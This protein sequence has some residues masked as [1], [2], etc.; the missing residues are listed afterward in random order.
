MIYEGVK[1]D[2]DPTIV[3]VA[4]ILIFVAMV[5]LITNLILERRK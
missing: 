5:I 2:T 3:A 4:A 1:Y